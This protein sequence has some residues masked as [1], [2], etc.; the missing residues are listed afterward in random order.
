MKDRDLE[1]AAKI[2]QSLLEQNKDLQQRTEFLEESLAKS[3]EEMVQMKH[4]LDRK[5]ELLRVYC[6]YDDDG[7]TRETIDDSL[8]KRLEKTRLENLQLKRDVFSMKKEM[9]AQIERDRKRYEEVSR[10]FEQAQQQVGQISGNFL[11][12]LRN[13]Q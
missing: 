2:G 8:K 13:L 12:F 10:Q 11:E 1:I 4:E 7:F 3:S 6:H 9:E 5:A